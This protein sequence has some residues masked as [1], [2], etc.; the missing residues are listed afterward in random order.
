MSEFQQ[1]ALNTKQVEEFYHDVFV[2]TQLCDFV[3]FVAETGLPVKKVIDIGG[4]CGYFANALAKKTGFDAQVV[5]M[6]P[7]S[8]AACLNIGV[9]AEIGD[10]LNPA[11]H[12]DEDIVSF[13]L[14]LH[15]L[16]AASN[17]RLRRF[18]KLPGW[19]SP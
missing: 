3:D 12:G 2:T 5:D 9:P 7:G 6:D 17:A 15:H 8:V 4:G 16:V 19:L 13:N 14:I 10:A 11:Q 1:R 18:L